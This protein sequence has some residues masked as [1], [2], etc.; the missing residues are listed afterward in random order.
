M[1]RIAEFIISRPK[2][3]LALLAAFTLTLGAVATQ[4]QFDA[5]IKS[6]TLSDDPDFAYYTSYKRMFGQDEILVVAFEAENIFTFEN[7][8][9]I[10]RLTERIEALDNIHDVRSLTNAEYIRGTED[11]FEPVPLF[12]TIPEDPK[13]L[14]AAF[15]CAKNHVLFRGDLITP[16]ARKTSLIITLASKEAQYRFR[17]EVAHIK[18]IVKEE[19]QRT[20]I[21]IHLAGEQYL[22]AHLMEYIHRDLHVFTPI[23]LLV[24]GL[25][26]FGVFRK[27]RETLIGLVAIFCSLICMSGLIPLTG[28]KINPVSVGL[29]PLVLCIA[30]TDVIHLMH[31]YHRALSTVRTQREA[32]RQMFKEAT[33]PC[34]LTSLTTAVGFGSLMF[35]DITPIKGF[36]MLAALGVSVCFMACIIVVPA[37]LVLWPERVRPP[38]TVKEVTNR[39]TAQGNYQ[40]LFGTLAGL[41]ITRSRMMASICVAGLLAGISGG[42]VL[43]VQADRT[44]YLKKASTARRSIDFVDRNLAGATQLDIC[45]QA[46]KKGVIKEPWVLERIEGLSSFLRSIPEVDKVISIND[47]LKDMNKAFFED[48]PAQYL[49]PTT[50]ETT[51]QYLLIYA[52]SGRRNELDKYVD[53]PYSRTRVSV[54]TSEHNSA[55]L[56]K[57]IGA[58]NG[59]LG[60]HFGGP[61]EARLASAAVSDN[62]V[63]NYLLWGL[64]YGLGVAVL[65]VALVMSLAFRSAYVGF[66]SILPNL[67]PIAACLGLMGWLG[68]WLDIA[69]A[70]TF[71][72]ALGIAVDD[73]IHILS[74]FKLELDRCQ[75][76]SEALE[77]TLKTIGPA[78]VQ[79]TIVI[80][81][82]FLVLV[83]ASL[84]MNIVFGLLA[85]F[86]LF[87]TLVADLTITPLCLMFFRP[88]AIKQKRA[89]EIKP[90]A[91]KGVQAMARAKGPGML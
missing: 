8:K 51:A 6:F 16:D 47:F 74:R 22:D 17:A 40:N 88:F 31:C 34:F 84:K 73:T 39:A 90:R 19:S 83:F 41:L 29:P 27:L 87:M 82:G 58:I 1:S 57:V 62:N 36:G 65:V 7:L 43:K 79:T 5:S 48:D 25:L 32:L 77:A 20:G 12:K 45:I 33:L 2:P 21:P 71:S 80:M 26:L 46:H 78:L 50:R 23:T 64:L 75:N 13:E 44:R 91:L 28:W 53:Y 61:L 9:L 55:K 54:R 86:I 56:D 63:F 60:E 89:A 11:C 81:G 24:I 38:R 30:V 10:E 35:N 70:M 14:A 18:T 66:V 37:L 76:Y 85:A 49:L 42:Y 68:I 69:T 52:M 3:C 67:F 15:E 72:I 59:Y 4:T